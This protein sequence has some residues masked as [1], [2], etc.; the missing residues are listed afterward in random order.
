MVK[1]AMATIQLSNHTATVLVDDEDLA[2]LSQ[3]NWRRMKAARA[4][5]YAITRVQ[6]QTVYM[7]RLIL[8]VGLGELT[9]HINGCGLDNR[10]CNLRKATHKQNAWNISKKS[11]G[12]TSQYIGVGWV[13]KDA[14]FQARIRT[15]S[16]RR[17]SIGYF[18]ND[19]DAALAY[20]A[21]ALELRGEFAR[22]NNVE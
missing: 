22:L 4:P 11:N 12:T 15:E 16:G 21:K 18:D 7:H 1:Y 13:K 10:R 2:W 17:I 19:R 5:E 3:Y 14:A 6:G 20:N 9:D 8:G